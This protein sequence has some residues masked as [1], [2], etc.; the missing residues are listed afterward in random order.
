MRD[1]KNFYSKK[2]LDREYKSPYGTTFRDYRNKLELSDE[3]IEL[4][5]KLCKKLKI[6]PFFFSA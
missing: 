6:E 3:Q 4:I 2:I 5:F 1:V